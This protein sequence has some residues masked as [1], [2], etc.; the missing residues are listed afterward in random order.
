MKNVWAKKWFLS[1]FFRKQL[2]NLPTTGTFL[3]LGCGG[4]RVAQYL[5]NNDR[6]IYGLD[7]SETL[8]TDLRVQLP[9]I[10]W[11]VGDAEDATVWAQLPELDWI[12]SNVCI[13]KDQCRLE[14]LVPYLKTSNLLLRIQ[15]W[16]DLSEYVETSYGYSKDEV[17]RLL[18]TWDCQI[19]EETY[20]QQFRPATYL[21]KSIKKIGLKPIYQ[22]SITDKTPIEVRREYLLVKATK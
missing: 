6:S 21:Y 15:S 5:R 7:T 18:A 1:E 22:E 13:R 20:Y 14:K 11:I 9:S 3:D 16:N 19:Q 17:M 2:D 12:V 4:G 10:S 8:I